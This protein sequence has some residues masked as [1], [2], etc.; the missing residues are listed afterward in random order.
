MAKHK[1]L[2]PKTVSLKE[3]KFAYFSVCCNEI[4][5]KPSLTMPQGKGIGMYIGA[6][7]ET[8]N[9]QGLGGWRCSACKKPCSVNRQKKE[10]CKENSST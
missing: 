2:V 9:T 7:P 3:A 5:Q 6:K 1:K 10:I 8:D 4:A